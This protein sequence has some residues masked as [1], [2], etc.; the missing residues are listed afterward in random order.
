M[1]SINFY[2]E[3]A[4]PGTPQPYSVYFIA[5]AARPDYTEVYVTDAAGTA[6]RRII[7]QVDIQA[8]ID[9]AI[10]AAG[11]VTVVADIAARDA[12]SPATGTYV[13]VEDASSDG[14]VSS[15]GA[16][17]YWNG[18]AWIKSTETES[19]DLV[20]SWANL[21]GKPT[22]SVAD[23]DDAVTKKHAHANATELD[24][25]GETGG[26]FTYD[27]SPVHVDWDSTGW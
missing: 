25:I 9:S 27:G 18:S 14:T 23:I 4:L 7:N 10:S 15:G 1:A 21:T 24:K 20:L 13:L 3:T 22:S 17:Y 26:E 12:L 5:P 8:M 11:G 19:M 2:R 6:N 16:T